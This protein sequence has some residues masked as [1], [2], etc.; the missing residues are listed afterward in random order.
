MN[1]LTP[2]KQLIRRLRGEQRSTSLPYNISREQY[3]RLRELISSDQWKTYQ[4]LLDTVCRLNVEGALTSKDPVPW[5]RGFISGLRKAGLLAEEIVHRVERERE[6]RSR[7]D[8][9]RAE[10]DAEQRRLAT[11]GTGFWSGGGNG[12]R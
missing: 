1:I 5:D 10:R 2:I 4:D 9:E 8:G 11:F 3:V 7:A 6:R 12:S